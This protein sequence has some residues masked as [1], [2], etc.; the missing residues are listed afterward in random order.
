M[1]IAIW[2][3]TAGHIFGDSTQNPS[4]AKSGKGI[5]LA[6]SITSVVPVY[7]TSPTIQPGEWASIY[8]TGLANGT[9]V[10][11][12]NYPI[13]LGGTSVTIKGKSAYLAL[14]S[15]TQINFQ[16][17]ADPTIG[18]AP[19]VVN[20]T[21]GSVSATV[22]LGQFAPTLLL[23]DSRHVAGIILR[24]NGS[25][26]YGGGTYDIIGPTGSSLGY[27][28]IAAKAGDS[29]ELFG[30]G[31]GPTNPAVTPGQPF[32]GAASTTSPVTL[33]VGG[34]SVTPSFAG[35]SG[36]GLDQINFTL[37][38]GLGTGDIALV[39]SVGGVSTQQ[40]VVA[41]MN[42][43]GLSSN[44]LS[45]AQPVQY[46]IGTNPDSF[47][48]NAAKKSVVSG[49]FNSD[50]KRDVIVAHRDD[51]SLYFLSGNG[52]GTFKPA[53]KIAI[54]GVTIEGSIYVGDFNND[55]RPDLFLPVS[56]DGNVISRPVIM[57]GNGDGSFTIHIDT[58]SSFNVAGTY[59]R[60][61]AVGDFNGDSKLDIVAT[62]PGS[63]DSG[64]YIILLG[65]GDGTFTRGE[66]ASGSALMHYSR[67]VAT[68][69][70][71]GDHKLDLAFADGVGAGT[72][73]G[74]SELTILLGNGD[75]TFRL[76]G[77]YASPGTPGA[78]TLNP[79]D[80]FLADLNNDGK[81][82]AVI[83]NYDQNINVFLGNGDGTFQPG[84]GYTTGEYPRGLE[85]ADVNGDGI[86]DIIVCNIGVG[87]GG[88]EFAKEGAKPGSVAVLLGYGD[89]KFKLPMQFN[90]FYYPGWLVIDDFNSDG[91]PDLAVTGVSRDHALGVMLN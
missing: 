81:L 30:T 74:T 38:A 5:S 37:P 34:A 25:G 68:G 50:G 53:V 76:A 4:N 19:V 45:F 9:T 69:D 57:F 56:S 8:G 89:G 2:S 32:S 43:P 6:P 87:P 33:S 70:F 24:S 63:D 88:A 71:N 48:P 84:A 66:V 18:S 55:G 44:P 42:D 60:G 11:T 61:Y 46:D 58:S 15:P 59:P 54:A 51:N 41:V 49:D 85:F 75:G 14:V 22:T 64:G 13:S 3:L 16:A 28:T 39:A 31:F 7:G 40:N 72:T 90:P 91:R 12:G 77:H 80:V 29:I 52:D 1:P 23:L 78:D 36:A 83:S 73:T 62:L 65:N 26:A 47:V 10:W 35:L 79:E 17:P 21:N 67:W 86:T 20:T 27:P 82:D